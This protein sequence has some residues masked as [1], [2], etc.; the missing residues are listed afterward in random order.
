MIITLNCL[1]GR[2]FIPTILSF[3]SGVLLL[4]GE[5]GDL[6]LC[7]LIINFF[8]PYVFGRLVTFVNC[9]EVTFCRR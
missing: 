7:H 4:E 8:F 9:G 1:L 3:S 5:A 6:F 2:L